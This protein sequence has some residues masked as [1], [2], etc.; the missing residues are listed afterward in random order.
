[1]CERSNASVSQ[2]CQS[3]GCW[4]TSCY[5]WKRKLAA[6]PQSSVFLRV[7]ALR[8]HQGL[9]RD[10]TPRSRREGE[11][12]Q[13]LTTDHLPHMSPSGR[14]EVLGVRLSRAAY[15]RRQFLCRPP[16]F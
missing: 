3:I 5:Q 15:A 4:P 16:G 12:E 10:Q 13:P 1:M 14:L 6:A 11:R 7:L 8:A 9:D 2:F